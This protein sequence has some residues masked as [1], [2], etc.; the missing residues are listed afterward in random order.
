MLKIQK[1]RSYSSY[2]VGAIF[3]AAIIA[4][5][6]IAMNLFHA[7]AAGPVTINVTTTV[8][9]DVNPGTGCSIY[10]ATI[11]ANTGAA[12]GGCTAGSLV[13][14][15]I[16]MIPAG[17]YALDV[18][19]DDSDGNHMM[20]L[21]NVSLQGAGSDQT[22]LEAYWFEMRGNTAA[23]IS[24]VHLSS[25]TGDT[26]HNPTIYIN[27]NG[28]NKTLTDVV[29]S[30]NW[31]GIAPSRIQL[32]NDGSAVSNIT[33]DQV[34][35]EQAAASYISCN[36][37]CSDILIRDLDASSVYNSNI[38]LGG[39]ENVTIEDSL[40]TGVTGA[41]VRVGENATLTNVEVNSVGV[42]TAVVE[43]EEGSVIDGLRQTSQNSSGSIS[44]TGEAASVENVEQTA[45]FTGSLAA[46]MT[47]NVTTPILRNY[48]ANGRYIS[49]QNDYPASS[50]S[51]IEIN[52]D[53]NNVYFTTYAVDLHDVVYSGDQD[54]TIYF[55]NTQDNAD[56]HDVFL[57]SRRTDGNGVSGT[58]MGNNATYDAIV[59][60]SG[61]PQDSAFS[62]NGAS[63]TFTNIDLRNVTM[64]ITLSAPGTFS[65]EDVS[66]D[67]GAYFGIQ[68]AGAPFT[69]GSIKNISMK[70]TDMGFNIQG[71]NSGTLTMSNIE[72]SDI[73]YDN[74]PAAFY[75]GGIDHVNIDTVLLER[76]FA[77]TPG[78][79][80]I[81]GGISHSIK[82]STIFNSNGGLMLIA[83]SGPVAMNAN[84]VTVINNLD[85]ADYEINNYGTAM[86]GAGGDVVTYNVSNSIFAGTSDYVQCIAGGDVVFNIDHSLASD[87]SCID[88]GFEEIDDLT[89][90]TE[91]ATAVNGSTKASTGSNGQD[92]PVKTL[93]L[94]VASQ[95]L[96]FGD[97]AT[98]ET[99]DARGV[100]R[101]D[102]AGCDAGAYQRSVAVVPE[103]PEEN[104]NPGSGTGSGS[105]S[106]AN[107]AGG[108]DA[109]GGK[110]TAQSANVDANNDES[111]EDVPSTDDDTVTPISNEDNSGNTD[112]DATEDELSEQSGI[113]TPVIVIAA[114]AVVAGAVITIAVVRNRQP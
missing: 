6:A 98:C 16:I 66:I 42:G 59:M 4:S 84:N 41:T 105:G 17:T 3:A 1:I 21:D 70:N 106:G 68:I 60:E 113:A 20:I 19:L 32:A 110:K 54:S 111:L 77:T 88:A 34:K 5:G 47:L 67:G 93:A 50:I 101:D 39:I 99:T 55:N 58:F 33:I 9:E 37:T 72:M 2:V 23:E 108:S 81:N 43:V 46:N 103:E 112:T 48:T 13:D 53:A 57:V 27:L 102:A 74:A 114:I 8:D 64:G 107:P 36:G 87:Q 22:F 44:F 14:G 76:V 85:D 18:A 86:F 40:V 12:Y 75:L 89:G 51:D 38:D 109:N 92:G 97:V 15:S 61:A 104:N 73:G 45:V 28:S 94:T 80:F 26:S 95:A 35:Q 62:F 65:I 25:V 49:F 71:G 56:V 96:A 52:A 83:T 100:V 79:I 91:Q 24:G 31:P 69:T 63:P 29:T 30:S 78:S 90:L 7:N 10:E 11:A 82:N